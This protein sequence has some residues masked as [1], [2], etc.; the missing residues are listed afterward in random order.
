MTFGPSLCNITCT[1]GHTADIDEFSRTPIS[2]EL[3]PAHYQCPQCRHAWSVQSQAAKASRD[4][5]GFIY[6]PPNLIVREN[7]VL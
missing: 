7:T 4:R 1:C 5:T 2:G 6:I 3:P